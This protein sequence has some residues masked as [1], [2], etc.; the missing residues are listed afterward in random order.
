LS[1]DDETAS[2]DDRHVVE[3]A[4]DDLG[5]TSLGN[6][7]LYAVHAERR[8]ASTFSEPVPNSHSTRTVD[9]ALALREVTR[10]T[11]RDGLRGV[12]ERATDLALDDLGC[13]ARMHRDDGRR[14]ASRSRG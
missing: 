12:L 14:G 7:A 2:D 1:S 6:R 8:S 4:R 3:P 10:V 11:P 13:R 9:T 5:V